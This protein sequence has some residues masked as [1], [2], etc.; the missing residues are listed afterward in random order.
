MRLLLDTHVAIWAIAEKR[1][2]PDE[3]S[4]F[5]TDVQNDVY[6]SVISLF[7]IA[8]K[9][10]IARRDSPPFPA[11]SAADHFRQTGF[12]LLDLTANHVLEVERI[13]ALHSDPF[14]RLLVSQALSEP[15]RLVTHDRR[16]AEYSDTVIHF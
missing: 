4:S 12:M 1:R 15:L 3:I 13:P 7:E 5:I 9:Y 11:S 6:V 2:L 16:L 10:S 8:I 14:D